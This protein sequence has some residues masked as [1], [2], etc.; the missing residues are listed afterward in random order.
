MP[1]TRLVIFLPPAVVAQYDAVADSIAQSRSGLIRWAVEFA[2][3]HVRDYALSVAAATSPPQTDVAA[4]DAPRR[5]RRGRPPSTENARRLV[6]LQTMA[7]GLLEETPG[8]DEEALRR[9][10]VGVAG[11]TLGIPDAS[12]LYE[13]AVRVVFDNPETRPPAPVPGGQLPKPS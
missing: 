10:L 8:M 6:Q 13:Q 3:P 1:L 12:P 7:R 9:L 11:A 4:A 5:R 2:L